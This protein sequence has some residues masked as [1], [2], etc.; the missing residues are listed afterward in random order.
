MATWLFN[1]RRWRVV[2]GNA[3]IRPSVGCVNQASSNAL[4]PRD[5]YSLVASELQLHVDD[6]RWAD[7]HPPNLFRMLHLHLDDAIVNDCIA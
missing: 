4:R 2:G 7:T 3:E 5:F 1:G 6:A